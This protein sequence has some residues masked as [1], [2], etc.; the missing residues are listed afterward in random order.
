MLFDVAV[1]EFHGLWGRPLAIFRGGVFDV[2]DGPFGFAC[3][4]VSGFE[5]EGE[6]FDEILG[7]DAKGIV[8]ESELPGYFF[9]GFASDVLVDLKVHVAVHHLI[10]IDVLVVCHFLVFLL[11]TRSR[12]KTITSFTNAQLINNIPHTQSHF[13]TQLP[14]S[15]S[16]VNLSLGKR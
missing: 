12:C 9:C 2:V 13:N 6:Y 3:G 15:T 16:Q 7:D 1:F 4:R 8:H 5:P 14:D 10:G 11:H